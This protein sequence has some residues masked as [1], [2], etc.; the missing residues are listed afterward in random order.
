M[1]NAMRY[2][3]EAERRSWLKSAANLAKLRVKLAEA[4][5]S[6]GLSPQGANLVAKA[7]D[8]NLAAR[9]HRDLARGKSDEEVAEMLQSAIRQKRYLEADQ[10]LID[11]ERNRLRMGANH[12]AEVSR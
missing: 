12:T 9:M 1:Q 4:W 5:Q 3:E 7:Y 2:M 6:L 8:P 10:L 11:Y